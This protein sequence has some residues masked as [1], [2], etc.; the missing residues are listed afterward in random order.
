M[1]RFV[2]GMVKK[3]D[4]MLRRTGGKGLDQ[5][6]MATLQSFA[7]ACLVAWEKEKAEKEHIKK[8]MKR[9]PPVGEMQ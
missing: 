5:V 4:R 6:E 9:A 7:Q 8:L 1:E 3:L 2:E